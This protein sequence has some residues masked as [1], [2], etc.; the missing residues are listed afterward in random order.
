MP[1]ATPARIRRCNREAQFAVA[2]NVAVLA[3]RPDARPVGGDSFTIDSFFSNVA[4]AQAMLT[5]KFTVLSS[6][7]RVEAAESA[8]PLRLGIDVA[9]SPT[10][11]RARMVD[12]TRGLDRVMIVKSLAV[13]L[14][15]D[16]NSLEAIG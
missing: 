9:L 12:S 15:T 1:T 4:H 16:R 2:Q 6:A 8:T 7:R 5:E 10:L 13:D 14:E 3:A 11:P